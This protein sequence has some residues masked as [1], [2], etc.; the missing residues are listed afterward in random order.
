[1]Q[2]KRTRA[3]L[4]V[5]LILLIVG[6]AF[7]AE[8]R[9]HPL[10]Q[11]KQVRVYLP[12]DGDSANPSSN[13][14]NLQPVTRSVNPAAPLRP[15]LEALLAGP[16]AQEKRQGFQGH[17][18]GGIYIVKVAVKDATAYASF[19]HRKTWAGWSGDLSPAAFRDG[20]ERTLKQFPNVSRTVVCVD[21]IENFYDESGGPEKKCPRF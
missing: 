6:L 20:V 16:T 12:K 3:H 10:S 9:K 19:A 13:P 5:A 4:I 7:Q 1:M 14:F 2:R 21:G 15:A 18:V 8:A 11:K 17:D